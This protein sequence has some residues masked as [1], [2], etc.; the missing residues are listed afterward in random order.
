MGIEQYLVESAEKF[1]DKAAIIQSGNW[2][3]YKE[4]FLKAKRISAL[5]LKEDVKKG[6]RIGI[7]LDDPTDYTV[8]YFGILLAGAVV[9]ALNTQ[10]SSRTLQSI[11]NDSEISI[12]FSHAK[13][14]KYIKEIEGHVPSFRLVVVFPAF[15]TDIGCS[16][17]NHINYKE[18]SDNRAFIQGTDLSPAPTGSQALAQIIYTSGTAGRPKG[19]M[20]THA[21]LMANT[22]SI[23]KYLELTSIERHM[24]VLPFFYS[25]GNSILLSHFCVGATM[26]VHQS[27]V[28]P[29]L[30]LDFMAKESVTGLSGVPST[31]AVLLSSG[32]L[33]AYHFPKLRY[34]AQ[35]GGAMSPKLA[36]QV[37][38]SWPASR[39][40]IMYGQTEASA[41]LS[42]LHP[43][44]FDRKAGSIGKAIP[45]VS[46]LLLNK[47][48]NPAQP[49]EIGEIVAVGENVMAGY[50][51]DPEGTRKVLKKEGLWTGDLARID[52]AGYFYIVSRKSEMIKSGA[53]RI[54]PKEIEEIILEHDAVKDAAVF[55]VEDDI[56]GEAI[57]ACI[58]LKKEIQYSQKELLL[59]CKSNLPAFKVPKHI[60][61]TERFPKTASGKV[62]KES[63]KQ[64]IRKPR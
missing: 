26:V 63:L 39:I 4:I 21:S 8:V 57:V 46:L 44:D 23:I 18:F 35:A 28:Y 12:L 9:V 20:L 34:V 2:I 50:W 59:H 54:A 27:M 1:S 60:V 7:L 58:I 29:K 25:F 49:G 33:S 56:L 42:F 64:I 16:T 17:I 55:G 22:R 5:L 61:C 6:D 41:R 13:F 45:G 40:Y 36:R 62:Q 38:A 51:K 15:P 10:T 19:V 52:E 31:F 11:I 53:H 37:K 3:S 30:I 47:E 32:A 24:V 48:G 43:D 14:L